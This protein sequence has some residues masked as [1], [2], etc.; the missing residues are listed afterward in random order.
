[1][2]EDPQPTSPA[3]SCV[4]AASTEQRAVSPSSAPRPVGHRPILAP[5][6]S[7]TYKIQFTASRAFMDKLR[8]AQELM[9]RR[10]PDGDPAAILEPALDLLID[11]VRKERFAVGRKPRRAVDQTNERLSGP[12][13]QD[14]RPSRHIPDAIKREVFERDEGRCTF[15]DDTGRR[16]ADTVTVEFD[17]IEGFA[18]NPRHDPSSMRLLC[19]AHN[20]DAA[21]RMYGKDFIDRKRGASIVRPGADSQTELLLESAIRRSDSPVP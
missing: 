13:V 11:D 1:M 7:A 8:Q 19:R 21:E 17:H 18:R 3:T 9:R 6:S 16:C 14:S 12:Q 20:L 4:A 2:Q 10:V 5:L 15:V